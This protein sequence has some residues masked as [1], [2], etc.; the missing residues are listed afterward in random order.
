MK[1]RQRQSAVQ[2]LEISDEQSSDGL[3]SI[4]ESPFSV[5]RTIEPPS[6][7]AA[8]PQTSNNNREPLEDDFKGGKVVKR[9][10]SSIFSDETSLEEDKEVQNRH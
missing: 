9:R 6:I 5:K 3:P 4:F 8:T 10:R 2:T 1:D 7:Q